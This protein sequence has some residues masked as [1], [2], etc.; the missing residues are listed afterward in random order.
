M[1]DPDGKINKE[2]LDLKHTFGQMDLT[3]I[4]TFYPTKTDYTFF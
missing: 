2:T 4:F 3:Y 1:D